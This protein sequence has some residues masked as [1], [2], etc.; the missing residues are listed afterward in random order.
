[1]LPLAS[2]SSLPISSTPAGGGWIFGSLPSIQRPHAIRGDCNY[3]S[4]GVIA[5]GELHLSGWSRQRRVIVA[6]RRVPTDGDEDA[7]QIWLILLRKWQPIPN[8]ISLITS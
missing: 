3:G 6:R 5:E 7:S 1:M 2:L 4:E 8:G